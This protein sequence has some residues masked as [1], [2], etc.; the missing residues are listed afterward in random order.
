MTWLFLLACWA[1]YVNKAIKE[2][3][4]GDIASILPSGVT[5]S[6]DDIKITVSPGPGLALAVTM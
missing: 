2:I 6:D 3:A 4:D 1:L 5:A